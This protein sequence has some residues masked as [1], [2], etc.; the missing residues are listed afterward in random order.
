MKNILFIH[1]SA[2]LYGSD[3]TLLLLI[4]HLDKTKYQAV[5]ILPNEGELKIELEKEKIKVVI[6]PV[7]KLY[8]KMFTPKN[9]FLFIK[10]IKITFKELDILNKE[11]KFDL[12][13]SNTLA[14]LLGFF[15]ARKRNIKHLWHVHEILEKPTIFST[16]F[17]K[18]LRLKSN[19][20]VVY[21]SIATQNFWRI[22]KNSEVI[23]N[24][25]EKPETISKDEIN[26]LR[27]TIFSANDSKIIIALVG[28]IS[29]WKGQQLLLRS[30]F[31]LAKNNINILLTFVGSPP[32]NQELFLIELQNSI[33]DFKLENQ[34]IIV[35]FYQEISKIWQSIDIAV[36]PSIE[37]EPFGLVAVEAMLAKKPVVAT[38][39]GGLKEIV[40]HNE[41]G[42]LVNPNDE[43][44]L[45]EALKKLIDNSQLR[46]DFGI[47]G[48]ETA[49]SKFTMEKYVSGFETIFSKL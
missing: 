5:V 8:R 42:F 17:R 18:L 20:L 11:Y 3:K 35:P 23:W 1:Q 40:N 7:L 34:V 6:A 29:S 19:T 2:E 39:H 48:Y 37:P 41:T 24:G 10:N 13:Y 21:N 26:H 32:P 44:A 43:V 16:V 33:L 14:V 36:I 30:F 4:K 27:Q 38:N 25:I 22:N 15:Y 46:S 47:A 49:L 28:R 9:I 12:V 31:S 45:A